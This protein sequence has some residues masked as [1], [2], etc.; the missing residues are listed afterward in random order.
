M[1]YYEPNYIKAPSTGLVRNRPEFILPDDAFPVLENAYLFREKILRKYGTEFLGRLQRDFVEIPFFNTGASPWTFNLLVVSGYVST[2]NNA[3]PGQVTTKYA[4]GLTTGDS[5]F[6]SGIVGA[7]GYNTNSP[8]TVTVNSTTTFT[9]G[10]DAAAYGAYVSGGYWISNRSLA[11]ATTSPLESNAEIVPGSVILVIGG[12]IT[13]TDQGD[14]TLTSVTPGN[15][16]TINYV[17]GS[18]T[19]TH[20]AGVGISTVLTYSYN[21]ALP[22]M[23]LPTQETGFINNENTLAFDQKYCYTFASGA[24]K[25]YIP[26]TV[27][28]GENY[29]LFYSQNYWNNAAGRLFWVTN[30]NTGIGGDPVRYTDTVSWVNFNPAVD[31][32][33][34]LWQ[35][36]AMTP[37]RNRMVVFNTFEGTTFAGAAQYPQRIRWSALGSPIDS[38]AW[39]DDI[40]GKGD[41]IDIPTSQNIVGIGFV[42]DNLVIFCERSTWQLRWT[43]RNITPF[44]LEKVNTELGAESTFS[45][46]QFDTSLIG[47]GDKGIIECD[48]FQSRRMDVKILDLIYQFNNQNNGL[49]RVYGIRDFVHKTAYWVYPTAANNPIF[50]NRRLVYNYEN[51][52]W[53][54]F[55][56]S[57]TCLGTYQ[58]NT[59]PT[60]N[61]ANSTWNNYNQTWIGEPAFIPDIV[62]GNQQGFVMILDERVMNSQSLSITGITGSAS[63]AIEIEV[64]NHNLESNDFIQ[65]NNIPTGTPFALI[66]NGNNYRVQVLDVNTLALYTYQSSTN[67]FIPQTGTDGTYI[68]GGTVSVRDNFSVTSKKFNYLQDGQNIQLGYVDVMTNLTSQGEISLNVYVNYSDSESVN[69][70]P[71]TDPFFNQVV[72][73]YNAQSP[74]SSKNIQR[75][76][77]NVRGTFITIEWTF[78]NAQ[79]A[80]EACEEDVQISMQT[81]YTRR[82][83]AQL[84]EIN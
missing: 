75:V 29:E 43:G 25:E 10:A 32:T 24:W 65:I 52:S 27:W 5:V 73:T 62:G 50:P 11:T 56:D 4:H 45:S 12:T 70:S 22:V 42:R 55:I 61:N 31:A 35:F 57:L 40:N 2:T 26:G 36:L 17:T 38:N 30:F 63:A 23:G 83:G 39:R 21:P 1:A 53:A 49:Q 69:Q 80:T 3:N 54:I 46:V 84:N 67:S 77:C 28:S 48:S 74:G 76:Y 60:W 44:Q 34:S 9:V 6:I 33:N 66:L 81:I 79:M 41:Y 51:D 15:S 47:I 64:I 68:G 82:A 7:T 8:F 14:G 37:F 19:I 16:G 18:V 71:N 20:T 13:L 72:P 58:P 59:S 78:S